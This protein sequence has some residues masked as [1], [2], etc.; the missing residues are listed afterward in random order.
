MNANNNVV[1]NRNEIRSF[2]LEFL[3]DKTYFKMKLLTEGFLLSIGIA[4]KQLIEANEV[5][6]SKHIFPIIRELIS[7]GYIEKY[8]SKVYKRLKPLEAIKFDMNLEDLTIPELLKHYKE[9]DKILKENRESEKEN[10][11]KIL[12]N[13]LDYQFENL[14]EINKKIQKLEQE[15]NNNTLNN[16][17]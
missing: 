6:A 2:I 3:K 10:L 15:L 9:R 12:H 7:K 11:K 4:E 17:I 14:R 13:S 1:Y 5:K 8:N 16:T